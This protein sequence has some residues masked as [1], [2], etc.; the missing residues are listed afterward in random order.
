MAR[1]TLTSPPVKVQIISSTQM[2]PL[3][4]PPPLSW[5]SHKLVLPFL[6][7]PQG[8]SYSL[9]SFV[10]GFCGIA[11]VCELDPYGSVLTVPFSWLHTIPL[12]GYTAFIHSTGPREGGNGERFVLQYHA[13]QS[14]W[15]F[16]SFW[17]SKKGREPRENPELGELT[18]SYF[19]PLSWQASCHMAF[20]ELHPG[21]TRHLVPTRPKLR[22]SKCP[23]SSPWPKGLVWGDCNWS[24]VCGWGTFG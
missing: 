5:F 2:L 3:A 6:N 8:E 16:T 7:F 12:C 22:T 9:Y 4:S 13:S 18:T 10:S 1:W 11:Y 21:L 24:R 15:L 20:K 14:Q 23:Y 17:L 19:Q